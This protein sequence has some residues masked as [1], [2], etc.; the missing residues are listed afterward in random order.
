MHIVPWNP[1][2]WSS[3]Q[4]GSGLCSAPRPRGYANYGDVPSASHA[5]GRGF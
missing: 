5:P 1:G 3:L 4:L 2:T